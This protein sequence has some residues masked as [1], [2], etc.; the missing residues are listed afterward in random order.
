M[1]ALG[2]PRSDAGPL[3][4]EPAGFV[5]DGVE[6]WVWW[7]QNL[8]GED[9]VATLRGRVVTFT[10]AAECRATFPTLSLAS[11][12][13]DDGED[14]DPVAVDLG[15]GQ[16]WVRRERLTVP[17]ES[18][19]NL[20]NLAIDVAYSTGRSFPQRARQHDR[21][22]DKLMAQHSPYLFGLEEYQPVWSARELVVLRE[23]LGRATSVLR[24]TLT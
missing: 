3:F 16:A 5:F 6:R 14:D 21:C 13:A 17:V 2:G 18:V 1:I 22:Y 7:G 20:W 10:S 24:A 19:L 4:G 11:G 23:T 12:K 8:D 9:C 15:P